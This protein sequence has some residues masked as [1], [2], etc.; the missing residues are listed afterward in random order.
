MKMDI[1]DMSQI[2]AAIRKNDELNEI[3]NKLKNLTDVTEKLKKQ[4]TELENRNSVDDDY[5]KRLCKDKEKVISRLQSEIAELN[6]QLSKL[7]ADNT[8]CANTKK[9]LDKQ[10]KDA[11]K[12]SN[13]HEE[14]NKGLS[15]KICELNEMLKHCMN[16]LQT[17]NEKIMQ[18]ES[19]IEKKE[20]SH[21][22]VISM[23]NDEIN[24]LKM[25]IDDMVIEN[26]KLVNE[27]ENK[28]PVD[29]DYWKKL[30]T[31][32]NVTIE[33]L[34]CKLNELMTLNKTLKNSLYESHKCR[35]DAEKKLAVLRDYLYR[36]DCWQAGDVERIIEDG[37]RKA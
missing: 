17:A 36:Y 15:N 33:A 4:V 6:Q 8:N 37:L 24:E 12:R 3:N 29:D 25:S 7:K 18:L 11:I 27:L 10:L 31:D 30:C 26:E 19:E 14:N 21:K 34:N 13:I 28:K 2:I 1:K 35:S 5:W 16:D 23:K 20:K 22:I 32:K 9:L